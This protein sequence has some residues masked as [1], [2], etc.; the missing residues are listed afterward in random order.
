MEAL[1]KLPTLHSG[2]WQLVAKVGGD[3]ISLHSVPMISNFGGDASHVSHIEGG[4]LFLV[5]SDGSTKIGPH[6]A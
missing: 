2:N 4:D 1:Y 3:Q 5:E 6:T